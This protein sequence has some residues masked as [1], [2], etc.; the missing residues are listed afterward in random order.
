MIRQFLLLFVVLLLY[1]C[2]FSQTKDFDKIKEDET[3]IW[4]LGIS[5]DYDLASKMALDD[6]IGKISVTVESKFEYVTQEDNTSISQYAKSVI[7]TYSNA[8]LTDTKQLQIHRKKEYFV[9]KYIEKDQLNTIF[10]QRENKIRDYFQLGTKARSEMRIGDALRY[11]YWSYALYLSHPYREEIKITE[12]NRELMAGTLL[13]DRI[14]VLLSHIDFKINELLKDKED[15]KTRLLLEVT[16]QDE[17]VN[18]LDFR[19]N[20]GGSVTPP[21]EVIGARSEVYLYGIE[22][23]AIEKLDINIEYKYLT[24]CYQDKELVSVFEAIQIPAFSRASKSIILP[25]NEV[26]VFVPKKMIKPVFESVNKLEDSKRFYTKTIDKLLVSIAEKNYSDAYPYFTPEGREMFQKLIQYGQVSL[27]PFT[28]TL[29]I[30]RLT[31]ETQVRSVPMTFYFPNSKKRFMENVVFTFNDQGLITAVSFAIS[32]V[33]IDGIV[34]KGANYGSITDK[35]TLIK[36]MEYYKTAY[37]LQR[38]DYIESIFSDN[39][40]IIV[41]TVL[42]RTKPVDALYRNI[43][44]DGVEYQRY[45]KREYLARLQNAFNSKEFIN[46]DFDEAEVR[47]MNGDKKIYGIQISQ[48]YYSSNYSDF[49]YLFLMIDLNDS[50][51]PTIYVRT[52]QPQKNNDGSIYG[53]DD[54]RL[55]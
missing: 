25:A 44:D 10:K 29:K 9:L 36:F 11:Y 8:R 12:D 42:K 34:N 5:E 30:I 52:W 4:G 19:C 51:N 14:N 45:T 55:N 54:F 53:L 39:A 32:D 20:I 31:D 33:T 43:G 28:D 40:L 38:L 23:Q 18:N 15:N 17:K 47:K 6:L 48:H 50:L 16:Y 13:N 24:K 27:V 7:N 2:G 22:Q 1:Y 46:I 26:K 21:H 37:N 3:Y 41:G 49:G 35:Y